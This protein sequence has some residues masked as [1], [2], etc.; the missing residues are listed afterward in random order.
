MTRGGLASSILWPIAP[1]PERDEVELHVPFNLS[2][3]LRVRS[4]LRKQLISCSLKPLH[5]F[6]HVVKG[7][8]Y[9]T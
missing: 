8:L 4:K 7:R 3:A 6:S 5:V 1:R 9:P 2:E